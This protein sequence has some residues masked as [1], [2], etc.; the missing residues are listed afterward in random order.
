MMPGNGKGITIVSNCC[1]AT[2]TMGTVV[3]FVVRN[4]WM[5]SNAI[6]QSVNSV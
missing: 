6:V 5:T 4:L 1:Y 3:F 2:I